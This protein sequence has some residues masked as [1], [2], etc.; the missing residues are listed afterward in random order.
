[1]V[2]SSGDSAAVQRELKDH[3]DMDEGVFRKMEGASCEFCKANAGGRCAGGCKSAED[4]MVVVIGSFEDLE[5]LDLALVGAESLEI[6][7]CEL[8]SNGDSL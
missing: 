2:H 3:D 6:R 4:M 8:D 5:V 1:M 7:G